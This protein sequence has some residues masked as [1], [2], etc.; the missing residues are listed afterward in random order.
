MSLALQGIAY[1]NCKANLYISLRKYIKL[2]TSAK[3][4]K[5]IKGFVE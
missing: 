3:L 1:V 5:Q 2:E 4:E